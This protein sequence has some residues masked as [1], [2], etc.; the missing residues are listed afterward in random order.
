MD[1][2]GSRFRAIVTAMIFD[3]AM[4]LLLVVLYGACFLL[5]NF[6]ERLIGPQD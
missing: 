3:L 4:L 6:A 5:V 1:Q 2:C